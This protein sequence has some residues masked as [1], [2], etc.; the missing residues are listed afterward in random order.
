MQTVTITWL[1]IALFLSLLKD[2][3]SYLRE[4]LRIDWDY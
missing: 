1:D 4:S 3:V 2:P